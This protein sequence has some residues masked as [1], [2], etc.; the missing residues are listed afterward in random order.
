MRGTKTD[1]NME[2]KAFGIALLMVF[3]AFALAAFMSNCCS[4]GNRCK[5]AG[6]IKADYEACVIRISHGGTVY[7][8]NNP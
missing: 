7:L 2:V 1:M 5:E 4:F 3:S 8:T 6:Y